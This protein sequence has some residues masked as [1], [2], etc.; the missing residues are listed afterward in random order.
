MII[1]SSV[2]YSQADFQPGMA[3][4]SLE[5]CR[6]VLGRFRNTEDKTLRDLLSA[7]GVSKCGFSLGLGYN[8]Y[9]QFIKMCSLQAVFL[10][11]DSS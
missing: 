10:K 2:F 5:V 6:R 9:F 11:L 8:G 7:L 1:N 4:N 3:G